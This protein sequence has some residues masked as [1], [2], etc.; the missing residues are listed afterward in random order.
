MEDWRRGQVPIL[1]E[2]DVVPYTSAAELEPLLALADFVVTTPEWPCHLTGLDDI[3]GGLAFVL[4]RMAPRARMAVATVES[5]KLGCIALIRPVEDL[6]GQPG[7]VGGGGGGGGWVALP[8]RTPPGSPARHTTA[9]TSATRH[10]ATFSPAR[11]AAFNPS[12]QHGA[13]A[14]SPSPQPRAEAGNKRSESAPHPP[15]Q[16]KRP[17]PFLGAGRRGVERVG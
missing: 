14:I 10:H 6:V 7:D 2:A 16:K 17:T 4:Q 8:A 1:V 3:E 5:C 12:R 13:R 11:K 15:S 9:P